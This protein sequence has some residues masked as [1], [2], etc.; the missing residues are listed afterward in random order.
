MMCDI[1][2]AG[3][4]AQ[5][6]QPE[7]LLG[8]I[9]GENVSAVTRQARDSAPWLASNH[10]LQM[11]DSCLLSFLPANQRLKDRAHE[12]RHSLRASDVSSSYE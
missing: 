7:I 11:D 4:K 9:P 2:Y 10:R 12:A 8:T 5:F 1:I 3:E 6:G